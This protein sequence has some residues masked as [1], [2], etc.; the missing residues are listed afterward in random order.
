MDIKAYWRE[1]KNIDKIIAK[2]QKRI[3]TEGAYENA[4]QEERR[5]YEDYLPF[6]DYEMRC[7]LLSYF[8]NKIDCL[9]Y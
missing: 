8:D 2:V 4:G 3:D 9:K 5:K 7:D 6:E 1:T